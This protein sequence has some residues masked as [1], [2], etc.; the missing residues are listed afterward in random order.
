MDFYLE[1]KELLTEIT[2][3]TEEYE[4]NKRIGFP[5]VC[6]LLTRTFIKLFH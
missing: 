6:K 5:F 4:I 1:E 2:E 3:L